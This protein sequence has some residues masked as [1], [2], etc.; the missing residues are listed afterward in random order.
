MFHFLEHGQSWNIGRFAEGLAARASL[1]PACRAEKRLLFDPTVVR[2]KSTERV[3]QQRR[4]SFAKTRSGG[5]VVDL[6]THIQP[7]S[8]RDDDSPLRSEERR[9]GKECR[10][11][12]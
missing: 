11:R 4:L 7:Q 2:Q 6:S 1:S 5:Q 3:S 10:S 12:G 9:V 8:Q